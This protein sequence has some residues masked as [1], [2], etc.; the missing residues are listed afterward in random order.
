M[1]TSPPGRCFS[2]AYSSVK[3]KCSGTRPKYNSL[4]IIKLK[5]S[6]KVSCLVN[7]VGSVTRHQICVSCKFSSLLNFSWFLEVQIVLHLLYQHFRVELVPNLCLRFT[8][9]SERRKPQV[10][11]WLPGSQSSLVTVCRG[12]PSPGSLT[13][14]AP[15]LL[16]GPWSWVPFGGLG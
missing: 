5:F 1:T 10:G 12:W 13:A 8:N 11:C 2:A 7:N 16:R 14:A 15:T 6:Q 3:A 4:L 9:E